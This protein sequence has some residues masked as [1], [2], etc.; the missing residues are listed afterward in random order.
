MSP[1][2][3]VIIGASTTGLFAAAAV[4]ASDRSV[5]ILERDELPSDAA[6]RPGVPQGRQPH[7]FLHRGVLA[8][9]ELLPGFRRDLLDVGAVPINTADL[10]WLG[11]QGWADRTSRS[12]EVLS[13][14]RPLLEVTLRRRV[15]ELPGV[16]VVGGRPVTRLA[17]NARNWLVTTADG[18]EFKA[19]LVIDASGRNSRLATWLGDKLSGPLRTTEIDARIGYATRMYRGDP[20][21]GEIPG[22]VIASTPSTPTGGLAISIEGGHWLIM[23]LGV[24]DD[25]PP[26]DPAGFEAFL[27]RLRDPALARLAQRLEPVGDVSLHRQT[28]NRRRYY[29]E[30]ND[31]PNS[32]V[33]MGDAFC[34][35]NPVYG[36][37]IAVGAVEA[38]LI[39]EALDAGLKPGA[40]RPLH[41]QF[42]K[43]VA[44]P[45]AVAT[46]TDMQYPTCP[47][48]PTRLGAL[49]DN[50]VK[51]MEKLSVHGNARAAIALS[52]IY[53]LMAG[54]RTLL[55]PALIRA[56][57]NGR[58]RGYGPAN[59][60][61]AELQD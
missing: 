4:A 24:G 48:S 27:G 57:L 16:D 33:V 10:A 26:R 17:E 12:F 45:W 41:R 32:V 39:R 59:R 58:I 50:W 25:R 30:Q 8:A 42:A 6:P 11:E 38:L 15:T 22:V 2:R 1:D 7:V 21:I 34:A 56:V 23:A 5:V 19:D 9:E 52:S 47:Q 55:Q 37:G 40:S 36:Q 3:V 60:R 51:Q 14:S 49:Q 53:H 28:A 13:T 31:W 46:A 18:T 43:A 20:L 44:L 29:D 35:F 54:P 61:P